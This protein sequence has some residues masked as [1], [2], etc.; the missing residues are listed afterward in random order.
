LTSR[1]RQFV[2]AVEKYLIENGRVTDQQEICIRGYLQ[3]KD[4]DQQGLSE[5]YRLSGLIPTE[6]AAALV[7][8]VLLEEGYRADR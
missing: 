3:G 8:L 2:E 6:E 4:V 5:R 1:E 7:R